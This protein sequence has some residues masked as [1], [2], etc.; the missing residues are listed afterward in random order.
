[1]STPSEK[2]AERIVE[3]LVRERLLSRQEARKIL[4]K[5]GQGKLQPEDWR[6]AIETSAPGHTK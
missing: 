1:M 3:R 6:A 2:L 4:T 5:L